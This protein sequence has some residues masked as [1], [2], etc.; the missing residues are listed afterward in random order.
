MKPENRLLNLLRHHV[1]GAIER[2][3]AIAIAEVMPKEKTTQEKDMDRLVNLSR[4]Y[5]SKLRSKARHVIE[6]KPHCADHSTFWR[7][8]SARQVNEAL[9]RPSNAKP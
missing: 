8:L 3:E 7:S 4:S 2:G 6:T 1:T 9:F 5:Q